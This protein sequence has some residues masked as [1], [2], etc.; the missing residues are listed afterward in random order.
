[1]GL[2]GFGSLASFNGPNGVRTSDLGSVCASNLGLPP[3]F[4]NYCSDRLA[5]KHW[6]L[7]GPFIMMLRMSCVTSGGVLRLSHHH[8]T[9]S[10]GSSF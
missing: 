3:G 7:V 2:A 5:E 9:P 6:S 4:T 1:M 8:W 10:S